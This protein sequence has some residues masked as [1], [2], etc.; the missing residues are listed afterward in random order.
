LS[1]DEIN[2]RY[3]GAFT[4]YQYYKPFCRTS[5]NGVISSECLNCNPINGTE[6]SR[7]ESGNNFEPLLARSIYVVKYG[8]GINYNQNKSEQIIPVVNAFY[9]QEADSS[10]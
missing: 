5:N 10:V 1:L 3:D 8:K 2:N 4:Y 7:S 9:Q 6:C